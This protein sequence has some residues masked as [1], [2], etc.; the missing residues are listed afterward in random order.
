MCIDHG[1][2]KIVVTQQFLY[3]PDIIPV[4]QKMCGKTVPQRMHRG[5]LN[6]PVLMLFGQP[7][8][9]FG[10]LFIRKRLRFGFVDKSIAIGDLFYIIRGILFWNSFLIH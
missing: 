1:R 2:L 8:E 4:F 6:L 9:K 10:G 7:A 5:L 3:R